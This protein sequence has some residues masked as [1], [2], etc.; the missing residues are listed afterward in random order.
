MK[1]LGV[2]KDE[3]DEDGLLSGCCIGG[4]KANVKGFGVWKDEDGFLSRCCIR[5]ANVKAVGLW[6][7]GL[8]SWCDVLCSPVKY[9]VFLLFYLK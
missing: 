3:D 9:I 5:G 6:R 7:D 2:W 4:A 8:L 1:E